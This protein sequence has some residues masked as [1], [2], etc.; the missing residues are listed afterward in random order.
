M[1]AKIRLSIATVIAIAAIISVAEASRIHLKAI[2]AQILLQNAW[3]QTLRGHQNIRPWSW[4]DF[5][6]VAKLAVPS[7]EADVIVLAGANGA[8]LPFGP[9]HILSSARLGASDN[10]VIAGHRDTHFKFLQD[11]QIGNPIILTTSNGD[12]HTYT[13]E[14]TEVVHESAVHLMDSSEQKKL[15]LITCWPFDAVVP[16]G[17]LRYVVHAV[18]L[19]ESTL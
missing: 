6:P 11:I 18:S 9:G 12:R 1:N 5:Y 15:T 14:K 19:N 4:A 16:G 7:L 13:V 10:A 8:T 3:S 17:P 2:L